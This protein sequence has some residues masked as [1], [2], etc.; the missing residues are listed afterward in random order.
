M[1]VFPV[2]R[3]FPILLLLLAAR[4]SLAQ[5][6]TLTDLGLPAGYTGSDAKAVNGKGQVT[7]EISQGTGFSH[8][9][10][11]SAGR[12]TDL[13]TLPGFRD[14]VG[15]ALN[16]DGTVAGVATKPDPADHSA[17]PALVVHAFI[18]KAGP[19][20]VVLQDLRPQG[21]ALYLSSGINAA[22]QVVGAVITLRDQSRAFV[23][24][25]DRVTFLDETVAGSGWALQEADAIND[26]GDIVGSGTLGGVR[27][28]FLFHGG[29]VTDLNRL[30]PAGS[31]W[32]LEEAMGINNRGAIVCIGRRAMSSHGFL[33]D[34]GVL[35]DLGEL[36]GYPNIVEAHLNDRGQ[37]VGE[38]ESAS[39]TQQCAFFYD[40]V[41]LLDLNRTLRAGAHW[42]L[43]EASGINDGGVIVGAGEHEGKSRA[44]LL[45]PK[46]R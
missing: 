41:R 12:M 20:A 22:G 1:S 32:A 11:Y 37:V 24:Q 46:E 45:T 39:G 42:S 34:G 19:G 2:L 33:L 7:G 15:N 9:F 17:H 5:S 43:M 21:N 35:T 28:A 40:G 29:A 25:G 27:H 44:F 6:Y 26:R 23:S 38:A 14:S 31:A 16:D 13:G 36:P 4:A 30:L 18:T 8:A 3:A 10:L